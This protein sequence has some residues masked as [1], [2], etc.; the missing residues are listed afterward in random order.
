MTTA[1][2]FLWRLVYGAIS[3]QARN[4]KF[5]MLTSLYIKIFYGVLFEQA[6]TNCFLSVTTSTENH[7]SCNAVCSSP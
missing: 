4:V 3:E 1:L 5:I 6:F 2:D 7:I